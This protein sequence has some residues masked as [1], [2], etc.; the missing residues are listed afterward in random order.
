MYRYM[1]LCVVF[2]PLGDNVHR[3]PLLRL[4]NYSLI[5]SDLKDE[6]CCVIVETSLE[7]W[8]ES[9]R[10]RSISQSYLELI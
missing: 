4:W 10:A 5:R 6:S 7:A 9:D 2:L 8:W 3:V 1:R